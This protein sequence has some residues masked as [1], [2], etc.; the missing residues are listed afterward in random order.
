M[1]C[2]MILQS[3]VQVESLQWSIRPHLSMPYAWD[4][5]TQSPSISLVAPGGATASYDMNVLGRGRDLT[6]ENFI[7]IAFTG[8][9]KK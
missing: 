6:Y 4:E 7:Y 1:K 2:D 8:T 9:F 3:C 5:P